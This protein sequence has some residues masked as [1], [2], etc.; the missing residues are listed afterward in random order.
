MKG[1]NKLTKNIRVESNTEEIE[2]K[3]SLLN[4]KIKEANALI[5][6]LASMELEVNFKLE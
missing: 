3:I 4:Q 1:I 2:E 6:E 5:D